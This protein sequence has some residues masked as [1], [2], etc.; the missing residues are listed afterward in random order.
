MMMMDVA[1]LH[2]SYPAFPIK[3]SY[4]FGLLDGFI[5]EY[6]CLYYIV[7][8]HIKD[9]KLLSLSLRTN[10]SLESRGYAHCLCQDCQVAVV[11]A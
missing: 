1:A 4:Y 2:L 7:K 5:F 10:S 6:R 3:T 8:G 9:N 11:S